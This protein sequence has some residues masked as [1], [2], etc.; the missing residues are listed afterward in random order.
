MKKIYRYQLK[1]KDRQ[2]ITV[3]HGA[4][5]ISVDQK[6]GKL[7][8]WAIVNPERGVCHD[9]EVLIIG[10]G[11]P[12]PDIFGFRFLGTCVMRGVQEGLVWHVFIQNN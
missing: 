4:D 5:I 3:P 1:F 11:N 10:T 7:C 2:T 12:M 8:V 6:D 9:V